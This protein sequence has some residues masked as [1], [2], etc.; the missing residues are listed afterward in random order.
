MQRF[1]A[2]LLLSTPIFARESVLVTGG[3]GY[4]GSCAAKALYEAGYQP[5]TLDNFET[6]Y[7]KN[8]RFGPLEIGDI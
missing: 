1:L 4:I 3:A 8:V 7:R 2:L 6:G 5:V